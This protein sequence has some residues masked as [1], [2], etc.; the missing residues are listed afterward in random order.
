MPVLRGNEISDLPSAFSSLM[1]YC[2]N[3][4]DCKPRR[5]LL[6]SL[7]ALVAEQ[8][9]AVGNSFDQGFGFARIVDLPAR[10]SQADRTS[11]N[12]VPTWKG[13]V[14]RRAFFNENAPKSASL[15][16]RILRDVG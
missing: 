10:Q 9:R 6:V 12:P 8:G 7:C 4:F 1:R 14:R 5:P 3:S 15:W 13:H 11:K 16:D 2:T